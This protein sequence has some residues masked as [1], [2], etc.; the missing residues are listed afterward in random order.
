[1]VTVS[2]N[3]CLTGIQDMERLE[4]VNLFPGSLPALLPS[5]HFSLP[6]GTA[7]LRPFYFHL[8]PINPNLSCA[9]IHVVTAT[10]GKR[11]ADVIEKS[12]GLKSVLESRYALDGISLAFDGSSCFEGLHSARPLIYAV[13][14][15]SVT[16]GFRISILSTWR[17]VI[18]CTL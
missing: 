5:R 9:V 17:S 1:M 14:S 15:T 4:E 11:N 13:N 2:E 6:I 18:P 8:Q 3:G 12:L 16:L 10:S 7:S